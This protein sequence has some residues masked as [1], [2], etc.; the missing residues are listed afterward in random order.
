MRVLVPGDGSIL[1]SS[2][3]A[4]CGVRYNHGTGSSIDQVIARAREIAEKR[5]S[6]ET[7]PRRA[8]DPRSWSRILRG[9]RQN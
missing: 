4:P 1:L 8:G 7:A 9:H 3:G 2:S 6:V 5:L